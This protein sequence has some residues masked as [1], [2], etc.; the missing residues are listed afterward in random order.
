MDKIKWVLKCINEIK[1]TYLLAIV[2]SVLESLAFILSITLQQQLI[3][4]V[5]IPRKFENLSLLLILFAASFVIYAIL[6][7]V[8]PHVYHKNV[9]K[10]RAALSK[11]ILDH[12]NNMPFQ[13]LQNQRTAKFVQNLTEDSNYI[14]FMIANNIPRGLQQINNVIVLG[15]LIGLAS[16][17]LLI[18]L[19]LISVFY[20][21]VTALFGKKIKNTTKQIQSEKSNLLVFTE[22]HISATREVIAFNRIAKEKKDYNRL[23]EK[24]LNAVNSETKIQ[25]N[26]M[27]WSES[28]KWIINLL[29]LGYAGYLVLKGFLALGMFIVIYQF[30]S[31]FMNS[32]QMIAKFV[33][34]LKG[35]VAYIERIE[36]L[37][38]FPKVKDG[39]VALKS[40]DE[41]QSLSLTN[42]KFS[43]SSSSREVLKK[44][45]I[46]FPI[47]K[48]IAIV[49]KSGSGKSTISKLLVRFIE[50][51]S[52]EIY[53]NNIL[54]HE[55]KRDD[56]SKKI[57]I[58]FQ[59]PYFFPD[60]IRN[61]IT[62]GECNVSDEIILNACKK[63]CIHDFIQS[64]PNGYDTLIGDRGINLSGGER[65]RLAIARALILNPDILIMDEATSALD[66]QTE[67]K[68]Q[69]SIDTAR[70]NK[71]TIIIA[72][73]LSTI[74]DA[75]IIYVLNQGEVA[76]VGTHD[77]LIQKKGEYFKMVEV[78]LNTK[79]NILL[80][81]L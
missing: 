38:S 24:Y 64:L 29:C 70:R 10:L 74:K 78:E 50:P 52:G 34:N 28:L 1:Y 32:F 47:N 75:D 5:F 2:L 63:A 15:C 62:F 81:N 21:L 39:M 61:N 37:L 43:Y 17:K 14:V 25:N 33:I 73:R 12:I 36:D 80:K 22:E 79:K 56:W 72:H 26:L 45:N 9:I 51:S 27:I 19:F 71:T 53:V 65:Q 49:G 67:R 3:D 77:Q 68:I 13:E 16:I 7:T 66:F 23:F 57:G 40:K 31:Q 69:E 58:I 76:E 48:K 41:V 44:V 54:L 60:T 55:I 8:T 46:N 11:K 59:E 4:D 30:T 20:Y 35:S 42:I 18:L 6:F